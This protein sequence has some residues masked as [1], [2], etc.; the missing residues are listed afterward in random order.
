MNRPLLDFRP[1]YLMY[2]DEVATAVNGVLRSGMVLQGRYVRECEHQLSQ[3]TG[4]RFALLFSSATTAIESLMSYR[5]GDIV[6][7]AIN[8]V[9]VPYLARKLGRQVRLCPRTRPLG[10]PMADP[11]GAGPGQRWQVALAGQAG[12][13]YVRSVGQEDFEDASQC[14]MTLTPQGMVGTFGLAGVYS[15]TFNKFVTAGEGG[16]VVTN[17]RELFE[18]L[19]RYRDFGRLHTRDRPIGN[20]G[21]NYRLSEISAAMLSVQLHHAHEIREHMKELHGKY[22]ARLADTGLAIVADDSDNYT[23]VIVRADDVGRMRR[24]LAANYGIATPTPIMDYSIAEGNGFSGRA[25]EGWDKLMCLP[26][27]HGLTDE[28][29]SYVSVSTARVLAGTMTGAQR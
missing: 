24:E 1:S 28:D 6:T 26:F 17:D 2:A 21:Y 19:S 12:D 16:C 14:F 23:R 15:F 22:A 25:E 18:Y 10:G 29:I 3:L 27:W 11:G 20:V 9:S 8:F 5:G 13:D 4:A 7:P